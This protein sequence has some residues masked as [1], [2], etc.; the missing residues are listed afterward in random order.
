MEGE[1]V[2]SVLNRVRAG[3]VICAVVAA[4]QISI[5]ASPA[6]AADAKA[7]TQIVTVQSVDVPPSA[8]KDDPAP[9]T[10]VSPDADSG[11][12]GP[13]GGSEAGRSDQPWEFPAPG[14]PYEEGPLDL[15]V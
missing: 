15:I 3:H 14:C 11:L 9:S 10:K 8:K 5:A 7:I 13:N 6:L 2:A 1:S 4:V 12:A